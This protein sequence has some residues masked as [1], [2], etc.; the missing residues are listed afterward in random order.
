S[1][2]YWL[3][4]RSV[5]RD[6]NPWFGKGKDLPYLAGYRPRVLH[7]SPNTG[8]TT[9]AVSVAPGRDLDAGYRLITGR[10]RGNLMMFP[11]TAYDAV[12]DVMYLGYV[13]Y[14][15][16]DGA[17][18]DPTVDPYAENVSRFVGNGDLYL[19]Y[20]ADGGATWAGPMNLTNTPAYDERH[21]ILNDEVVDGK[22]HMFYIGDGQPGYESFQ[23]FGAGTWL[24]S[25]VYYHAVSASA[26]TGIRDKV[27][28]G[29]PGEFALMQNYPNPFNPVTKIEFYLAKAG[30]VKLNVYNVLGQKI[31]TLLDQKLAAGSHEIVWKALDDMG[32]RVPSGVYFYR[33]EGDF[34]VQVKKMML[35]K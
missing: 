8:L 9:A 27:D 4:G 10:S 26:L 25:S 14:T 20:S 33:I 30:E 1:A 28:Q 21:L 2:S 11:T 12:K 16:N 19:T 5:I 6:R 22:V 17:W 23:Y 3:N 15:E 24:T 7:W 35:M 31:A 34:G 13:Q 18:T 32:Y 29:V